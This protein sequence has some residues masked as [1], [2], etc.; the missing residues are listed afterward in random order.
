MNSVNLTGRLTR[1]PEADKTEGKG[2]S[3]SNMRVAI[4]RPPRG[5][6]EQPAQYWTVVAY[7]PLADV[8]NEHLE[9]GREVGVSGRLEQREFTDKDGERRQVHE[10]V[11][12][13]VDFLRPAKSNQEPAAVGASAGGAD[14]DIPF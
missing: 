3:V 12:A 4:S 13:S 7:G 6:E 8:C 11:A 9:K 2:T 5:G 14:D 10:I 1:D